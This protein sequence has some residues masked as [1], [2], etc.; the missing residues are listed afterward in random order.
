MNSILTTPTSY[1]NVRRP[2][3]ISLLAYVWCLVLVGISASAASAHGEL[4]KLSPDA[5]EV[6]LKNGVGSVSIFFTPKSCTAM[7]QVQITDALG[8][9]NAIRKQTFTSIGKLPFLIE[10]P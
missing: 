7:P 9:S 1:P 3:G 10:G 2:L 4:T 5:V 8:T 6:Q